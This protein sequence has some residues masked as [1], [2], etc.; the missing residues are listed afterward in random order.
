MADA[1]ASEPGL[2]ARYD[3]GG[4]FCEML[5]TPEHPATHTAELRARLNRLDIEELR[6]RAQDAELELYNFGVTFTVYS[7]KEAIDRILPFDVN[8]RV[9][10]PADWRLLARG[11]VQRVAALNAFLWDVY[12]EQRILKD[13]T[14]P[15]DLVL[16]NANYRPEMQGF[17]VPRGTYVH[18]DGT[19]LVR[20][21]DGG[22]HVLE[23]NAR[24]PSGVSYV[25][26][27]RHLML[28]TFP[29]LI[30]ETAV[31]PVSNYGHKLR[32]ALGELAPEGVDDPTVVLLSPGTYNSAYFE[33]I[34][35]AREMGVPLVEGRDLTVDADD[36]VHMKTI[37]GPQPVDV[38]YR[39]I[40]D[41]FLDP[42]VFNPD[43]LLGVAGLMRASLGWPP[44]A[45]LR[46]SPG[47][48]RHT[49]AP[50]PR[51]RRSRCPG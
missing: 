19:D 24:T 29:D 38:I 13:G 2:L 31:R 1:V 15:P 45:R 51:G 49:S 14:V 36:R 28:R 30:T 10:S 41:D 3:P 23:D 11:V 16:G 39:R 32:E 7:Q 12:H 18:I 33:H 34:F 5:G 6:R 20:G 50:C 46:P 48:A 8:P 25:V 40:N 22:F 47:T 35:L 9:L 21:G 26:E 44:R 42:E 17:D 43:S 37:R 27:N 4:Y